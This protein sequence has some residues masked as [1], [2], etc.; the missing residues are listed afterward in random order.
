MRRVTYV[1]TSVLVRTIRTVRTIRIA[2]SAEAASLQSYFSLGPVITCNSTESAR[3]FTRSELFIV[4]VMSEDHLPSSNVATQGG[5][6]PVVS[7]HYNKMENG[8]LQERDRSR[9][10]HMRNFNNWIKSML[11]REYI[12]KRR[13]DKADDSPFHVLDL[14]AGK[15]GDL[16]KWIKGSISYLVCADIAGTSVQH[17]KQR[18]KELCERHSRQREPSRMFKAEFITADC[19]KLRKLGPGTLHAAKCCRVSRARR[20]LHWHHS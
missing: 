3:I 13:E 4:D 15:G 6:A 2:G 12:N 17:A 1:R 5:L 11:I 18:Y 9:I 7:D 16:L 20:L 10:L 14:G 8:G 19:T